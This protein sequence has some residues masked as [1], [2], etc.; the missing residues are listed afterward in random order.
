[1]NAPVFI[2]SKGDVGTGADLKHNAVF[3][4]LINE[5]EVFNGAHSVANPLDAKAKCVP[6]AFGA[7]SFASMRCQAEAGLARAVKRP[8]KI[9]WFT[10]QF[11][12]RNTEACNE[13]AGGFGGANCRFFRFFRTEMANAGNDALKNYI[14]ALQR[15]LLWSESCRRLLDGG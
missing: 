13:I 9:L 3:C 8:R 1:M 15:S 5:S 6:N 2:N 11:V 14:P 7:T 12:T 10:G 4:Q